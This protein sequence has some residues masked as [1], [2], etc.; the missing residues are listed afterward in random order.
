MKKLFILVLISLIAAGT[1]VAGGGTQGSAA[2]GQSAP[3][4]SAGPFPGKIAIVS[5]DVSQNEEEYRAAQQV[6]EKY[7]AAK[8]IHKTWPTNFMAEQ[9][10]MVTILAELATD[11]DIK[12]LILNQAVPGSN[13]AVD[14]FRE[15]RDD[16]FIIYCQPQE[17]PVDVA[18]RANLVFQND[19]PGMGAPMVKQAKAQGAKVFI[20]YSFP[21]HMS[22]VLLASRRDIIRDTCASEGLQYVDAT[23]PDPTGDGGLPATQ[24]FILEDV[25]RM[26]ARYGKDTAFFATNCGMQIP[27]I[28]TIVDG[29]AIY[30]QP[31]CPSPTH[32]FPAALGIQAPPGRGAD[33]PYFIAETKRIAK[34]KGMTGRLS[35]WPAPAAMAWTNAGAEYAIK[36]LNGQIS[37]TA[38][39]DKV[40]GECIGAYAKEVTGSSVDV[41]MRPYS[42]AGRSYDNFKMLIMGY[43]TY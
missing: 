26:L 7:G 9:E 39:D 34:E 20:H 28:K 11:R 2:G 12:V 38:I 25:P 17:N 6:V 21:R 40:L 32:G 22:Q 14:K 33:M 27:L 8:V 19:S 31:C 23:A 36:V 16:A 4:A 35:T 1:L 30:P 24:Q 3:A 5:S 37:K 15:T 42:E 13:P 18:R 10:Q 29:G 43:L 41:T